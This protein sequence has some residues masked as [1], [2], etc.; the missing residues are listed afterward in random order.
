V[1]MPSRN[2]V[3][4]EGGVEVEDDPV[5]KKTILTFT[6][7]FG[8]T[9]ATGPTGPT[10]PIGQQGATGPTGATGTGATG[11]TGPTGGVPIELSST[12]QIAVISVDSPTGDIL[13]IYETGS[14]WNG[15]Y[16]QTPG[17][18]EGGTGEIDIY[19]E[20]VRIRCGTA[21]TEGFYVYPGRVETDAT[22]IKF[23]ATSFNA[24]S[25]D[26]GCGYLAVGYSPDGETVTMP[27]FASN[28]GDETFASYPLGPVAKVETMA[29]SFELGPTFLGADILVGAGSGTVTC[30][31]GASAWVPV[32]TKQAFTHYGAGAF[33]FAATGGSTV[34][35]TPGASLV[36]AGQYSKLE[37]FKI[38][39]DE[40]VI[41]GALEPA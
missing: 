33:Q 5:N 21:G 3:Q 34:H 18:Q 39:A 31:L 2:T 38:A 6:G 30:Y 40:W 1:L 32:N 7:S 22:Q 14:G 41:Y 27:W 13:G 19:G 12:E 24:T 17:S 9:G 36:S 25:G 20:T 11:P 35:P 15:V 8:E 16:L 37:A 23:G 4:Y 26:N 29:T 10:G 28:I